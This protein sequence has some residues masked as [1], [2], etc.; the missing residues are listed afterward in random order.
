MDFKPSTYKQVIDQLNEGVYF[1]DRFRRII[2]WNGGAERISGFSSAEVVGKCCA[3]NILVHINDDGVQLCK[4]MCPLAY[5]ILD[6]E[7]RTAQVYLHHRNGHRI[8]V[9]VRTMPMYSESGEIIGAI[10]MF[11]DDSSLMAAIQR[12]RALKE[13]ALNDELTGIGNRR[14]VSMKLES[15]LFD[16]RKYELGVGVLMV[17]VDHFKKINDTYG[18]P[19]GDRVLKMVSNTINHNVRSL[20]LLGRWGGDEFVAILLNVDG[21]K[22][23]QIARKLQIVVKNSFLRIDDRNI[24]VTV[25]VGATLVRPNDTVEELVERVDK[26]LY[27]SKRAGRDRATFAE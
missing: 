22:A 25:S 14:Y 17:D 1:V 21:K 20:D 7:S 3:D 23:E 24:H 9:T 18:H 13:I 8:P 6:G 12:E 26:L 2:Y 27:Q 15:S 19:V 5:T 10:E 11:S 4:E 16:S